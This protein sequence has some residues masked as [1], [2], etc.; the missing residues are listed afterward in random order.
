MNDT[1]P[2]TVKVSKED[3]RISRKHLYEL[4]DF[5]SQMSVA[6]PWLCALDNYSKIRFWHHLARVHP[7][8]PRKLRKCQLRARQRS[9]KRA[10]ALYLKAVHNEKRH[11]PSMGEME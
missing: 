4:Y 11:V 6:Q 2:V 3:F 8:P 1:L 5:F 9:I 7:E 10:R